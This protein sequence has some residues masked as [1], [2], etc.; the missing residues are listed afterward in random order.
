MQ[1][2]HL[3]TSFI[4]VNIEGDILGPS[5]GNLDSLIEMPY[6]CGEQNMIHFAPNIYV[7]QYLRNTKQAEQQTRSK[8]MSYMM[9]GECCEVV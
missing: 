4:C 2:P 3:N 6:G 5:I 1:T 9:E 7:L 8:A